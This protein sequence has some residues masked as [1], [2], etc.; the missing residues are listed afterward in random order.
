MERHAQRSAALG[1]R[2]SY[3]L[4]VGNQLEIG[5]FGQQAGGRVELGRNDGH[6]VGDVMEPVAREV[7][8][9]GERRHGDRSAAARGE[10]RHPCRFGRLEM[11]TQDNS[12]IA[13]PALQA[14]DVFLEPRA[15]ENE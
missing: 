7:R 2:L 4:V 1:D 14:G 5:T 11:R 15:I 9:L 12:E 13:R 10:F 6:R 8:R 3:H